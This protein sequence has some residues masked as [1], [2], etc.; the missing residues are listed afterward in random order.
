MMS[1]KARQILFLYLCYLSGIRSYDESINQ[2]L[3]LN[4]N[5]K[6]PC[7]SDHPHDFNDNSN[8][9]IQSSNY[10]I[11]RKKQF[12]GARHANQ[13]VLHMDHQDKLSYEFIYILLTKLWISNYTIE[14]KNEISMRLWKTFQV[15]NIEQRDKN[16]WGKIEDNIIKYTLHCHNLQY[17]ISI[18]FRDSNEV[19]PT[20]PDYKAS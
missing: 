5:I 10:T 4:E 18:S 7:P 12:P 11:E 16:K 19:C 2:Y 14:R 1:S 9:I 20:Q 6:H 8:Q 17:G 13:E 15:S 3:L